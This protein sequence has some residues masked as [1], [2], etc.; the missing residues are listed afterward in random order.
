LKKAACGPLIAPGGHVNRRVVSLRANA[1]RFVFHEGKK[2][3]SKWR[4]ASL[5]ES[6][7][8]IPF[9]AAYLLTCDWSVITLCPIE[10]REVIH[11][12]EED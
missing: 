6:F 8:E 10:N 4:Q 3:T 11:A 7:M 9:T 1:V 2:G 12:K 5:E